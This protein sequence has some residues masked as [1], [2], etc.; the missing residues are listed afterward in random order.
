M[1]ETCC[2]LVGDLNLGLDGCVISVNMS[3]TTE[4]VTACGDQALEGPTIG[5]VNLSAYADNNVWIGCPSRAGVNTQFIRKYDCE[6]DKIYFIFAGRGQSFYTG[7]ADR[8]VTLDQ[9]LNNNNESISA[10][11]SSGPSSLYM[12]TTQVNGYGMSY[13]GAPISFD[14]S[15]EGTEISL[16]GIFSGNTYYLQSFSFEAQPGQL[17]IVSYSLVY[18]DVGGIL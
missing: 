13:A 4:V 11:S 16:G 9:V 5:S 2:Q 15:A 3:T 1:A 14:T 7:E 18:S 6:N 17:P 12:R 10:S 8:F